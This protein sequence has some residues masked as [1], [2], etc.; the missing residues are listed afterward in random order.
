MRIMIPG[1]WLKDRCRSSWVVSVRFFQSDRRATAHHPAGPAVAGKNAISVKPI[2]QN[3]RGSGDS[4]SFEPR[5]TRSG[6]AAPDIQEQLR[7]I[8]RKAK[9]NPGNNSTSTSTMAL[10]PGIVNV[11][12]HKRRQSEATSPIFDLFQDGPPRHH[13]LSPRSTSDALLET[14]L[15]TLTRTTESLS[16]VVERSM[17]AFDAAAGAIHVDVESLVNVYRTITSAPTVAAATTAANSDKSDDDDEDT[18][19]NTSNAG[20]DIPPDHLRKMSNTIRQITRVALD[21]SNMACL[22]SNTKT[23]I[24]KDLDGAGL[25]DL[26]PAW[27]LQSP[28]EQSQHIEN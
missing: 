15:Q 4:P 1:K 18:P 24:I 26:A 17:K 19:D 2:Y 3:W 11:L 10:D 6:V 22:L 28:Q 14:Q 12:P 8:A 23:A 16:S 20:V 7:H 27:R 9:A 13:G 25:R 5:N 21:L